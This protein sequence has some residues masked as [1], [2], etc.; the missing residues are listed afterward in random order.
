MDVWMY[1]LHVSVT[2]CITHVHCIAL[3]GVGKERRTK[4]YQVYGDKPENATP[5]LELP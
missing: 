5:L 2:F 3:V 4:N 1:L